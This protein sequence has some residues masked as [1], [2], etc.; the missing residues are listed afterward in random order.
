MIKLIPDNVN[1]NFIGHK[2]KIFVMSIFIIVASIVSFFVRGLNYGIDFKGGYVVE[3][4]FP[5][6]QELDVL[7]QKLSANYSGD[8]SLQQLGSDG[9]DLVIKLESDGTEVGSVT[10]ADAAA[11]N[12]EGAA[13]DAGTT[14]GDANAA[15][16][17][18]ASPASNAAATLT[19]DSAETANINAHAVIID[20]IKSV[21]GEGVTYRRVETIGPT[22][23]EELINNAIKAVIFSILAIAVYIAF[24]F[25][26]QFSVCGLIALAQDCIGVLGAYAIFHM[27]FNATAIVAILTTASYSV[28]DSIVIFDRIR[29]N[30]KRYRKMSMPELINKS[31][32]E[33]LS[34]TVLTAGTTLLA[35]LALCI[36]GGEVISSFSMPIFIGISLGTF[37]SIALSAPL[38][39]LLHVDRDKIAG[40]PKAVN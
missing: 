10:A 8:F 23:G 16:G 29:E 31:I 36:F 32:N 12:A 22:V 7:R 39:L 14:T 38:L 15:T 26:W 3:A 13:A 17:S 25:E 27:E 35:V 11:G 4:R 33:T 24:R 21:L 37:S 19:P 1:I 6:P 20:K 18:T 5:V 40:T 34:R 30:I 2:N 28:N 9:R